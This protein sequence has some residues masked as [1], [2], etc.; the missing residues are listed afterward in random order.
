MY[1]G[2]LFYLIIIQTI[3][4]VTVSCHYTIPW[5]SAADVLIF[6][7]L[8]LDLTFAFNHLYWH[9]LGVPFP[10]TFIQSAKTIL[11]RLFRVYAHIYHQHFGEVVQLSEEAH[12]NTSFKHFIFFV[13][14]FSLIDKRELA[15]LQELIE[16]LTEWQH[17]I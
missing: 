12:L 11:K 17:S 13:Q 4:D 9:I 10:K 14:E 7:N 3:V 2:C 5:T 15:P 1:V 16:K 8:L 6:S